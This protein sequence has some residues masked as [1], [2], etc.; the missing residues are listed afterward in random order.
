MISRDHAERGLAAKAPVAIEDEHRHH[1]NDE[2]HNVAPP[3]ALA[4][5][6]N[7]ADTDGDDAINAALDDPPLPY[8]LTSL[9][10]LDAIEPFDT[11]ND[12]DS[13]WVP[14]GTRNPQLAHLALDSRSLA[15]TMYV[16]LTP[17]C[18]AVLASSRSQTVA[19]A[20]TQKY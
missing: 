7:E 8:P 9:T 13:F 2:E 11:I 4:D 16:C 12:N 14:S 15:L 1:L 18:N 19:V 5:N 17:S 3:T 10:I 6:G 20:V